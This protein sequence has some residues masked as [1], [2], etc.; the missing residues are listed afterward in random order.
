ME[1]V[2]RNISIVIKDVIVHPKAFWR[3]QKELSENQPTLFLGYFF[4]LVIIVSLGEFLGEFTGNQHFY[5]G[6]AALK[7]LRVIILF[8]LQYFIA[9]FMTNELVKPFGGKKNL[10][11]IQKLIVYSLTPF[12]L[13]SFISALF[14][15]LY[16]IDILGLYSFYIFWIGVHELIDFPERNKNRYI[17]NAILVN[18]FIFGFLSISLSKLL[19]AYM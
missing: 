14:P 7:F 1:I 4:P 16:I 18:I 17:L 13:S 6:Y 9:V 8:T 15:F 3:S 5:V 19:M 10:V 12:L 11:D 2:F